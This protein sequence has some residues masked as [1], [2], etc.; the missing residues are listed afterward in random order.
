MWA[1]AAPRGLGELSLLAAQ[2]WESTYCRQV[3]VGFMAGSV[4]PQPVY[5]PRHLRLASP[6]WLAIKGLITEFLLTR[7]CRLFGELK[8]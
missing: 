5:K 2:C 8:T 3:A 6:D 1:Q 7:S 4:D